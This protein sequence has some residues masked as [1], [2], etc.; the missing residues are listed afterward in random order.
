MSDQHGIPTM[1]AGI[2]FRSRLEAQWAAMFDL[3]K[4]PW[5]YEPFDCN[6]WIPDFL[7]KGAVPFLLD[8]KPMALAEEWEQYAPKIQAA[9][10]PYPA[11]VIGCG[12]LHGSSWT[13]HRIGIVVDDGP[14]GSA[15]WC[16]PGCDFTIGTHCGKL[17]GATYMTAEGG[18]SC[19]LCGEPG[20]WY[21]SD[22]DFLFYWAESKNQVR[23]C[24][25]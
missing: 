18:W 16:Y 6:G 7:L 13:G 4:W 9:H 2:Q 17:Q 3:L 12:L 5:D 19:G 22:L 23:W 10:P 25:K 20:K 14:E 11:A 24:P 15:P 1:Y 8:V 21:F